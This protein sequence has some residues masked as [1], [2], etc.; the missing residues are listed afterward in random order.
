MVEVT[1]LSGSIKIEL[2]LQVFTPL[3]QVLFQ[4]NI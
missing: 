1:N 2:L 3:L 4:A